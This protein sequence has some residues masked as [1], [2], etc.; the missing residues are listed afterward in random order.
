MRGAQSPFWHVARKPFP[1]LKTLTIDPNAV[2][3]GEAQSWAEI[4]PGMPRRHQSCY[5]AAAVRVL[6]ARSLPSSAV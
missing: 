6:D 4:G 3:D 2:A 1:L 5:I